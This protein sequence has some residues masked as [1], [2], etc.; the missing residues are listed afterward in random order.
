M[1]ADADIWTNQPSG[2]ESIEMHVA[3]ARI[4]DV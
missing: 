4:S 3:V 1:D 2:A